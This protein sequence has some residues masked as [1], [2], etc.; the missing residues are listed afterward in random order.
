MLLQNI[1]KAPQYLFWLTLLSQFFV[2]FTLMAYVVW[3]EWFI[4]KS[5]CGI[6]LWTSWRKAPRLQTRIQ[7]LRR[8]NIEWG[9]SSSWQWTTTHQGGY[10]IKLGSTVLSYH[11]P[12]TPLS[13]DLT[14]VTYCQF[15]KTTLTN[16]Q[17]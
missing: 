4:L 16:H 12:S 1:N 8:Q 17:C 15:I 7:S 10:G 11:Q 6:C 3:H 13:P 2:F 14:P 5:D 9:S